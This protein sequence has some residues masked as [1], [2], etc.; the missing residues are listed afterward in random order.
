M[1][2]NNMSFEQ[3]R[4]NAK[5]I[6]FDY[7]VERKIN[8]KTFA[9]SEIEDLFDELVRYFIEDPNCKFDLTKGIY[10]AG[11]SGTFK[12]S[13]IEIFRLFSAV[14]GKPFLRTSAREFR[15]NANASVLSHLNIA[16][17]LFIDDIGYESIH[18][19][20]GNK[21]DVIS[22]LIAERYEK[23]LLT[24]FTTNMKESE[25]IDRYGAYIYSRI[26]E[27]CNIVVLTRKD[28]RIEQKKVFKF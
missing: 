21:N 28:M 25:I 10:L 20:F 4:N 7:M 22:N 26:C 6:A 19:E 13:L 24:H 9:W 27:M 11:N 5:K 16:E 3:Y 12:T 8:P 1:D 2:M 23:G 18:N 15:K 14:A 17:V